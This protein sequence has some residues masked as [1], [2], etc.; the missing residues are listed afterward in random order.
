[1]FLTTDIYNED[2]TE[3]YSGTKLSIATGELFID[4]TDSTDEVFSLLCG[5]TTNGNSIEGGHKF[6]GV[7]CSTSMD[8]VS[9]KTAPATQTKPYNS[10]G[11]G[12]TLVSITDLF[13]G[14]VNP[15]CAT[16]L[17]K[18]SDGTEV[19]EPDSLRL[20]KAPKW[21]VIYDLD[22]EAGETHNT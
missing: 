4:T 12:Q 8:G 2:C 1:M 17:L 6:V 10:V 21:E 3:A 22:N 19:I 7:D 11:A 14:Y 15:A 20:G 9:V 13:E 5:D 16:C 18:K